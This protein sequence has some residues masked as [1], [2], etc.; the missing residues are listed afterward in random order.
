MG[1]S[2]KPQVDSNSSESEIKKWVVSGVT[3]K[4]MKPI[5]TKARSRDGGES[6]DAEA[7]RSTTPTF[8]EARIPEKLPCPPAPRKR[9]PPSSTCHMLSSVRE[10]FNPPDLETVFKRH[11]ERAK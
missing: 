11:V 3:V 4:A 1:V 8:K 9:R 10:F 5:S 7:A 2:K 6:D